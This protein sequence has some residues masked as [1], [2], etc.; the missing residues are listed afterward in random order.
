VALGVTQGCERLPATFLVSHLG[1]SPPRRRDLRG[2]AGRNLGGGSSGWFSSARS[3][4]PAARTVSV[5]G[6][7]LT[8]ALAFAEPI[9]R[10]ASSS[11]RWFRFAV[12]GWNRSIFQRTTQVP[13]HLIGEA[14]PTIV[15]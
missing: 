8:L 14:S 9:A 10:R 6:F 3:V 5:S 12:S 15:M 11:S 4:R 7:L 1:Y 13:R 2:D